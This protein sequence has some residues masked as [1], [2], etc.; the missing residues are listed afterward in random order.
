MDAADSGL[1]G[2]VVSDGGP[3]V[4]MRIGVLRYPVRTTDGLAHYEMVFLDA[5]A[6][7][8][9]NS[10]EEIECL[11]GPENDFFSLVT[12]GGL[13][14][15]GLP[16]RPLRDAMFR[17]EQ[18]EFYLTPPQSGPELDPRSLP[19]DRDGAAAYRKA[20]ID[21]VLQL[22][23]YA[24]P[25]LARVPFVMPIF[26]LNH[27]LQPEFPEVS[28]LGEHNR[29][30]YLYINTCRFATFVLVD[31]EAGKAD[32]L[33]FYGDHIGEDR[34][35]ILPYYPAIGK[36]A[37]PDQT[38]QARVAAKYRLPR[39][40]Y[41]YPAQFWRHKNHAA[42]LHA[43]RI[44]RDETSETVPVVF[45]GTYADYFRALNFIELRKLANQL[46]IAEHVYYLGMVPD[47]DMAAL[48][49]LSAGLVMPTFF[50]PTNLPPLEAWHYGRPVITSDIRGI[51]EQTGDAGL[52]A[53]P[54][55]PPH[56]ARAMLELWRD[57]A[58]AG[59]LAERGRKRLES[60]RWPV[61]VKGVADILAEACDRVRT[62]RTPR[63]P[64]AS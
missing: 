10:A 63:F 62:G 48:Y 25:F 26:D 50:G 24:Y 39:R 32:V 13:S 11:V 56:L 16:I 44:I 12:T 21:L 38:D 54:K 2:I 23:P 37:L 34:I 36:K 28:A 7:A 51:R 59:T 46:G 14:Y 15:R 4:G 27:R 5:L 49:T 9:E 42:I 45:C 31:S 60:Y 33:R 41:F 18:P 29:R 52:L 1:Y 64:D 43:I 53:D 22:G 55:S 6:E 61:Y 19:F 57:E 47:E 8:A 58:L 30:E 3:M 20:G 35:R 17:Q 40:Y